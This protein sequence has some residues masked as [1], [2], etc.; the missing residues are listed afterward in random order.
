MD[1]P[2][3]PVMSTILAVA[4]VFL[5]LSLLVQVI[6]ELYKYLTSSRAR[7]YKNTLVDFLGPHAQQLFQPGVMPDL[8]VRGPFQF[9]RRRPTGRLQPMDRDDLVHAL[10]RTAAPW[11]HGALNALRF[12]VGIQNGTPGS[13][14]PMMQQFLKELANA[15]PGAEGYATAVALREFFQQ[16][17]F[18][19]DNERV[20]ARRLLEALRQ[21]FMPAVVRADQSF[22]QLVKNFDQ[23]YRRRNLRQTFVIGFL[24]AFVTQLPLDRIIRNA[25]SVPLEQSL[26]AAAELRAIYESQA[27]DTTAPRDPRVLDSLANAIN[28]ALA[29]TGTDLGT[30]LEW[31]SLGTELG[32]GLFNS[33]HLSLGFLIGCLL[34]AVLIS[35]GAPVWNDI[36]GALLRFYKGRVPEQPE[37][38]PAPSERVR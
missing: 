34:S 5:A 8:Q 13:P 14:S 7:S 4:V 23:A 29:R 3:V 22:S 9:L 37:E 25:Q 15:E 17:R 28:A 18:T 16:W 1:T 2:S 24:L 12:E 38:S 30:K 20:D 11:V 26:Q 36:T 6:Q 19:D 33:E 32:A 35:F 27:G 21:R 31:S 10:E